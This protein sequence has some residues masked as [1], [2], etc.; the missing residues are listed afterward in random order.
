MIVFRALAD[1]RVIAAPVMRSSQVAALNP[2]LSLLERK[3]PL[4]P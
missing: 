4:Q 1:I 3:T 2:A